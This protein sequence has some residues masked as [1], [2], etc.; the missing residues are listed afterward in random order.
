MNL[1]FVANWKM[2]HLPK[3]A[4]VFASK[5][6]TVFKS[7]AG[8]DVGIA[9]PYTTMAALRTAMVGL[10]SVMI[11]AQNVHWLD[12]GAH[13]G[14]ISA[15]MLKDLG[16]S[17]ALAGHS[18]RRQFYGETDANV[19]RRAKTAIKHGLKAIVCIGESKEQF[20]AGKTNDV[21]LSQLR[22]SL[23]GLNPEEVLKVIIGYEPV[24]AI[25]TG[26]AATKEDAAKVH[27]VIRQELRSLFGSNGQE[28]PV[29]YGGSTSPENIGSLLSCSDIHGALVGGASLDPF[30]FNSL[31][32]NG[33][34]GRKG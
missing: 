2:N 20:E 6:A 24:W 3:D 16:A 25:G 11:G 18:E 7:P 5:F 34:S 23:A 4:E 1:V 10:P 13:T 32:E 28:I 33:I 21:V 9:A 15:V 31:I 14:E 27:A 19:A 17:F 29:I 8:A 22:G 30:K 26:L 12:S